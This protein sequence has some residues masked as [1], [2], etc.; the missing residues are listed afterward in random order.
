MPSVNLVRQIVPSPRSCLVRDG[1]FN[2]M[3]PERRDIAIEELIL[4]AQNPRLP[5]ELQ[6][7]AQGP[8][9]RYLADNGAI[10]ELVRSMADNGYFEHEPLIVTPADSKYIVLEG[11]RR[12]AALKILLSD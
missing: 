10:G 4:D 5:E 2:A 1:I 3:P 11:N 12:L 7:G 6:G 9:L 8:V